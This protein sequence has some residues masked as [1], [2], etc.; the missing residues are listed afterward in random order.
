MLGGIDIYA[1]QKALGDRLKAYHLHDNDGLEDL[2]RRVGT[3]VIDWKRFSEGAR[4]FTPNAQF[5]M[6]YNANAV[7]GL[8]DYT[9]DASRIRAMLK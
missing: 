1:V 5:I 9:E 2:H 8:S 6:E 7:L 3:G 4:L